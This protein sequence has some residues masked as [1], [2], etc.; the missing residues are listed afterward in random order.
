MLE[1][2]EYVHV[3]SHVH[4][5]TIFRAGALVCVCG[6]GGLLT[7]TVIPSSLLSEEASK[8][9]ASS[10]STCVHEY[11]QQICFRIRIKDQHFVRTELHVCILPD[12]IM[13]TKIGEQ[14]SV[15][16]VHVM[17]PNKKTI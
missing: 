7:V 17:Y 3:Q 13:E 15:V 9:S 16:H 8:T 12:N 14:L 1:I 11:R 4:V 6:G 10:T 5:G 2:H